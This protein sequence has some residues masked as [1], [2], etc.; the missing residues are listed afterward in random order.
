MSF[1][2][3]VVEEFEQQIDGQASEASLD[4]VVEDEIGVVVAGIKVGHPG[5]IDVGGVGHAV[6][7]KH[8]GRE[9]RETHPFRATLSLARYGNAGYRRWGG[10]SL[11]RGGLETG[12]G[13]SDSK[14]ALIQNRIG[15]IPLQRK[16]RGARGPG[17]D[18][19]P[20]RYLPAQSV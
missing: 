1:G 10:T 5:G 13:R 8:A 20:A 14:G 4:L 3:E 11:R 7:R 6:G 16:E 17:A 12:S 2:V 18:L 15:A 9:T 19:N